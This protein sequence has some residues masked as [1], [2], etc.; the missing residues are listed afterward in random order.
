MRTRDIK[1]RAEELS[2]GYEDAYNEAFDKEFQDFIFPQGVNTNIAKL[3]FTKDDIQG[4]MDSFTFPDEGDWAL[5]QVQSE[6]ED[7]GDQKYEQMRDE[8]DER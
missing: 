7:I 5:D 3:S 2:I 4:F 1:A 6:I 8:R